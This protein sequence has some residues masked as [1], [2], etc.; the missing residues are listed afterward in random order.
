LLK[1]IGDGS[2]SFQLIGS[3]ADFFGTSLTATARKYCEV[4]P[5]ECAVV[6][7]VDGTIRWMHPAGRF[8]HWIGTGREIMDQTLARQMLDGQQLASSGM[9]EVPAEAWISDYRL[10]EGATILEES[11]TMPFYNG[12]LSLLWAKREIRYR[13]YEEEE[14]LKELD[15]QEF[16]HKRAVW[17]TKKKRR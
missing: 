1:Q 7:S 13:N 17:P 12:C 16:T 2:P 6:W 11:R 4:A 14:R 3:L 9:Q 15:P 5:Q 8:R 10:P